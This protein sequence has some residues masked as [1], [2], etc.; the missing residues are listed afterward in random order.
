MEIQTR[1]CFDPEGSLHTAIE[2]V[3]NRLQSARYIHFVNELEALM[4]K[5]AAGSL[6]L[7]GVPNNIAEEHVCRSLVENLEY[8]KKQNQ[9]GIPG[10]ITTLNVPFAS[11]ARHQRKRLAEVYCGLPF[12]L[13][14]DG[15]SAGSIEYCRSL[16]SNDPFDRICG[17][18]KIS[19]SLFYLITGGQLLRPS[20]TSI[21]EGINQVQFFIQLARQSGRTH[22]LFAN[23]STILEWAKFSEISDETFTCIMHPYDQQIGADE[24]GFMSYL[25][26]YD[27][28]IPREEGFSL[29]E[30]SNDIMPVVSG[31]PYRLMKWTL[32]A[33]KRAYA[34][35][36]TSVS[37][38]MFSESRPSQSECEQA[39]KD[40]QAIR[41]QA[42]KCP[43]DDT[44][45][46]RSGRKK[47]PFQRSLGRDDVP[48]EAA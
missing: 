9:S 15:I 12:S 45:R 38:K 35:G 25:K 1:F 40:L 42:Q 26:K 11:N 37:W 47:K 30:R 18:L 44:K 34:Q 10:R 8:A 39:L 31:C 14:S 29:L 27:A 17:S 32:T 7:A 16:L 4:I 6:I 48:Q 36:L 28:V 43:A 21:H 3:R 23:T 20:G 2:K 24:I 19:D 13:F 22:V 33:L 5:G 41:E 46:R